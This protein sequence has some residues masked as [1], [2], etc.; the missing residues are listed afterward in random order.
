MKA[1]KSLHQLEIRIGAHDRR[2]NA[3][4]IKY[5]AKKALRAAG[6]ELNNTK[7]KR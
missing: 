5:R 6:I 7:L 1:I 3:V 4:A 2:L